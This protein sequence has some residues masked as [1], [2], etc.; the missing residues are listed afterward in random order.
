MMGPKISLILQRVTETDNSAGGYVWTWED[1][2]FLSGS[3][4]SNSG[5]ETIIHD[6]T[7]VRSTHIFYIDFPINVTITEKDRLKY[8]SRIFEILFC[9]NVATK[10]IHLKIFLREFV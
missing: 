4:M 5:Q 9:E 8:G 3:L 10:N 2:M 1:M 6:K 7:E